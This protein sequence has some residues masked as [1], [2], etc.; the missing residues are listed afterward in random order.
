MSIEPAPGQIWVP[1]VKQ[2]GAKI[3]ARIG[4][5]GAVYT[6]RY[7]PSGLVTLPTCYSRADWDEWVRRFGARLQ[8][9]QG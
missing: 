5:R 2:G 9:S 6:R 8:E 1:T 3:I 4:R 7:P